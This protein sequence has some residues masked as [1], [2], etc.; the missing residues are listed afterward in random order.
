MML[1]IEILSSVGGFRHPLMI[2]GTPLIRMS[3]TI[4]KWLKREARWSFVRFFGKK[5][6]F[7]QRSGLA[8]KR[9]IVLSKQL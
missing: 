1:L 3:L 8:P 9:L 6:S 7:L 4:D 2:F 5:S